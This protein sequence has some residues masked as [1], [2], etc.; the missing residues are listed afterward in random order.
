MEGWGE[1]RNRRSRCEAGNQLATGER[2]DSSPKE[3]G[4]R[5]PVSFGS[6]AADWGRRPAVA[7]LSGVGAAQAREPAD[8]PC[9]SAPKPLR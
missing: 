9:A 2:S 4:F 5:C 3:V 8:K 6:G 1:F 7:A